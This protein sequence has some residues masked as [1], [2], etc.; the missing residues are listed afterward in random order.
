MISRA[1]NDIYPVRYFIGWGVVQ[2]LQ[3]VMMIVGAAIVLITV[4][5]RLALFAALAMP[6]IAI[7][8]Y[9]FAHKVFPISRMVQARKGNLT[10]ATD[11]AVVGIEM[12]QAFGREDD[13]RD[14]FAD[15][16]EAVRSETMRQ[17]SVEAR[18]LPGLI[19]L[20]S[21]GIAAV[22]FFGGRDAIAGTLTIGEFTLFITLLL[23][24][25]WPLEALGWIINLGQRATAAAVAQ[26]RLARRDRAARPSRTTRRRC[27]TGPLPV[28]FEDVHFAYGTGAEVLRGVD[29][30]VRAGRDRRRLRADRCRQDV[31]AQPR[32][33]ASTTRPT[34]ACSSA[35][36]TARDVALAELRPVGRA[37]DAE[38]GALLGAAAREPARRPPRRG[39]GRR[40][41]RLRGGRRRARSSTSCRTAT[42]R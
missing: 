32:C 35:A 25:V 4:N 23:Q 10:E 8:T 2:A 13:V 24:L 28:R 19:F 12:V 18:F 39:L 38:A 31:A 37:R 22:L 26:L 41:R 11:E 3:S 30:E 6:P 17:A 5:A 34:G 1:T 42:T 33:R 21:L 27:R 40:A 20:P 7:L 9:V 16:A 15:R 14:G 29:L 36:S